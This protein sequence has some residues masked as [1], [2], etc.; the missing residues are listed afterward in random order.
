M[1]RSQVI[2]VFLGSWSVMAK[3][4]FMLVTSNVNYSLAIFNIVWQVSAGCHYNLAQ[5]CC[6]G[7]EILMSF[8][9]ACDRLGHV[10]RNVASLR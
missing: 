2:Q 5:L 7:S 4:S 1:I 6:C 10:S 3:G 9:K 8:T